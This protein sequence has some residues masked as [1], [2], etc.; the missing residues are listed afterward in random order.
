[1]VIRNE[2]LA[3]GANRVILGVVDDDDPDIHSALHPRG[4]SGELSM[5]NPP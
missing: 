1:M 2:Y 4:F 3:P 5:N